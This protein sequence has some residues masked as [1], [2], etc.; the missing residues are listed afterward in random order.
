M[1]LVVALDF[2]DTPTSFNSYIM[3]KVARIY[4][5]SIGM[6]MDLFDEND[7]FAQLTLD[8]ER[9]SKKQNWF[10]QSTRAFSG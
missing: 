6:K 4:G 8:D 2:N 5:R 9:S 3:Y 1:D 10:R 7:A